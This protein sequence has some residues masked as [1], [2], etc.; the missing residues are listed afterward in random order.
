MKILIQCFQPSKNKQ[1]PRLQ[2]TKSKNDM[3]FHDR[4]HHKLANK[5]QKSVKFGDRSLSNKSRRKL[6]MPSKRFDSSLA[7]DYGDDDESD[8]DDCYDIDDE[9]LASVRRAYKEHQNR[10]GGSSSEVSH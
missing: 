9:E 7:R 6:S 3:K 1:K 5:K 2:K 4:R 10:K 8:E